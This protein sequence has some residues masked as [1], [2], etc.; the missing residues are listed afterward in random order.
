MFRRF[1]EQRVTR[2]ITDP[3]QYITKDDS[4]RGKDMNSTYKVFR[5]HTYHWPERTISHTPDGMVQ[6]S[7]ILVSPTLHRCP[8][9]WDL[10]IRSSDEYHPIVQVRKDT[11]WTTAR[12]HR[13]TFMREFTRL[14]I[15]V[16]PAWRDE[17]VV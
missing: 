3:R 14:L 7:T 6:Q 11:V 4:S 2:T 15:N 17:P 9:G 16:S 5:C 12:H 10:A 8:S 1:H 13:R